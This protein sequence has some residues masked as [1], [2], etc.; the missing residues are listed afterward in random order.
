[1]PLKR[2]VMLAVLGVIVIAG[3]FA[4]LSAAYAPVE[5][6]VETV[7]EGEALETVYATGIV[8]AFERRSLRAPRGAVVEK[9]YESA[10]GVALIEG[11]V[12]RA[13]TPLLELR[14]SALES[15][16]HAAESEHKR[17]S[18]QLAQGS[19]FRRAVESRIVE[20]EEVAK[21][22]RAREQRLRQQLESGGISRDAY[23]QARTLADVN[24]QRVSQLKQEYEQ[25]L[26]DLMAARIRANSEVETLRA[27][28]QDNLIVAPIDG[29]ILRLPY[30]QGEFA[31]AG[32]EVAKVGDPRRLIIEAE[33]Y[34]DDIARVTLAQRVLIRLASYDE[35][36]VE[37]SVFEILPDAVR[38]TRGYTV[39]VE[40]NDAQFIP[41]EAGSIAGA[42]TLPNDVQPRSGMSAELGIVVARSERTIV[43]PRPALA[44]DSVV[45]V[46]RDRRAIRT[47]VRVGLSSFNTV[48]ALDGLRPGDAVAV[49]GVQ[50]LSHGALVKVME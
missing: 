22:T 27:Q 26:A 11:D 36:M 5:V 34:E 40:F 31:S 30:K 43:F 15:R 38:L 14:D 1:V 37:G 19:P 46:I 44:P 3:V 8:E 13:G 25:T 29:V 12:V 20:A 7:R 6:R 41:A 47:P 2:I 28:R 4:I 45:Y 23:D 50:S 10:P 39:R 33:V 18:E 16:I 32:A 9:L 21:D 24:A 48:E 49:T 35:R 42:I 17:V